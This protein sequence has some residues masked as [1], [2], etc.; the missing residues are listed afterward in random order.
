MAKLDI[1][2]LIA[3]IFSG[4]AG[5]SGIAAAY[6]NYRHGQDDAK[7]VHDMKEGILQQAEHTAE[8]TRMLNTAFTRTT[9]MLEKL[10]SALG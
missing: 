2:A 8:V 9:E 5:L 7:E 3:A 6:L 4:L 1:V 10:I